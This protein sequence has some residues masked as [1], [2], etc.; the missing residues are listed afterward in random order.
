MWGSKSRHERGYGRQWTKLRL[1]VLA[2]D[3]HLCQEHL[4]QGRY[5]TGNEVDHIVS[6]A[7]WLATHGSEAGVDALSNLQTIC[8]ACHV[9]KTTAETGKQPRERISADGWPVED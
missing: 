9:R 8:H 7:K 6:K 2:R 4:R 5:V 3:R 1:V